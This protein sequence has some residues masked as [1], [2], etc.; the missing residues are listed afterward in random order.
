MQIA[1]NEAELALQEG[2]IPVGAVVV[3]NGSILAQEH[4]RKEQHSD[5]SA[6]A[7]VLAIRMAGKKLNTW[8]LDGASLYVTTEPCMM[9][10][11]AIL[12]ARIGRVVYGTPSN[13]SI[14][15]FSFEQYSLPSLHHIQVIGGVAE[16][17]ARNLI[18]DFFR[19]LR[20]NTKQRRGGRVDEGVRLE[21]GN[22]SAKDGSG[23][24][25][26]PS[27]KKAR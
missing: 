18:Q 14:K 15:H 5:A 1:L 27:P 2:E 16:E 10:W 13:S 3:R 12:E 20:K 23:V 8:R 22:P 4:N 25:I 19:K 24:R 7:E 17:E 11:G 6:H 26:P 21:T 9:C